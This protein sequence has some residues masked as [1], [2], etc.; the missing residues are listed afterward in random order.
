MGD[1]LEVME[2]HQDGQLEVKEAHLVGLQVDPKVIL[3]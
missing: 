3:D 1:H 2:D